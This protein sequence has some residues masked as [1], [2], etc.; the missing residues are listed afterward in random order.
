MDLGHQLPA[1]E[2]AIIVG[3]LFNIPPVKINQE[4]KTFKTLPHRLELIGRFK[5][6]TF[7]NDSLATIPQAAIHALKVLGPQVSTLIAGGF[8]RG[9]D[10]SP[11]SQAIP[12]TD[13]N[14]LI[15]L[16]TTGD[17]IKQGLKPKPNLRIF[18]V[19]SLADAVKLAFQHTPEG[20]VCLMSPASASF[21]MFRD[22]EQRGN[23]FKRL[24]ASLA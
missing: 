5:G 2:V 18:S 1:A 3:G 11:L 16:P 13:L 21:N 23:E 24:V 7:I 4:L 6:I 14:T 12:K 20:K 17:K 15:L 19:N 22:Y 9:V 10:Y 8:D